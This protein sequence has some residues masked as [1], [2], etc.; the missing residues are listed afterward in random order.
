MLPSKAH[1]KLVRDEG[2]MAGRYRNH[3]SPGVDSAAWPPTHPR[4]SPAQ[5]LVMGYP[6]GKYQKTGPKI[7]SFSE[8][9]TT[10]S[11]Q[12]RLDPFLWLLVGLPTFDHIHLGLVA[13]EGTVG[14]EG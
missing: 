14:K 2:C 5:P 11:P 6:V 10:F 8:V 1:S 13:Q 3:R 7:I 9:L 12:L 4:R